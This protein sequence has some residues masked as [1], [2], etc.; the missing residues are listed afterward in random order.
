MFVL[1]S[2]EKAGHPCID[3]GNVLLKHLQII[4]H[5]GATADAEENSLKALVKATDMKVD[6]VEFD[7]MLSND[8]ELVVFH[9]SL[10]YRMTGK[11]GR[12][13]D[14]PRDTLRSFHLMNKKGFLSD[15]CIPSL[16]EVLDSLGERIHCYIEMKYGN[17]LLEKKLVNMIEQRG[18]V[19][20]VTI[21]SF[22]NGSLK[23]VHALN[24]DISLLF[25]IY[26]NNRPPCVPGLEADFEHVQRFGIYHGIVNM[27]I[28]N[29][30]KD[31]YRKKVDVYTVD[32]CS[33]LDEAYYP[34]IDG[35]ITN[36]PE[37]WLSLKK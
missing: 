6:A 24:P 29:Y 13:Q 5:R 33:D 31:Y 25:L 32:T 14:F 22:D 23:R 18:L 12:V 15:D 27:E 26:D 9:D 8:G 2:C 11:N 7:V 20:K 21:Q 37:Y 16:D 35:I 19:H 34:Y 10:L 1:F 30:L 4:A 3:E 17:K 36:E 28:L